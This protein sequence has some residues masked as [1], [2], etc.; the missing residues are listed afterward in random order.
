ME[1]QLRPHHDHGATRVIHPLSEQVLPEASLL[2]LQGV[3]E[4]LQGAVVG[5]LQD[6]AAPAVVE[7]GVHRLL[8]HALLV[9][10]DDL[11]RAQ[12]EE[13]LQ[14]VVPVDDAPVEVVQIRSREP[15]AIQG[16][17]W[18]QL[19]RDDGDDV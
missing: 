13:L 12:L 18:P 6:A 2:A 14:T 9:A 15:A 1:L 3:G 8:Q 10:H 16:N 7:E 17:Q 4:R 5:A 19:G 11:G